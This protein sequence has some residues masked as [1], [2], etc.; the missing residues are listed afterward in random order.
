MISA[1]QRQ[2]FLNDVEELFVWY[3]EKA[4]E[5]TA[6]AFKESLKATIEILSARPFKGRP[7]PTR[8][9]RLRNLRLVQV[10]APFQ[11][12]LVFY[13]ASETELE[14]VR[15]IHGARDLPRRLR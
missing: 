10:E 5:A 7:Y 12:I 15:L 2:R 11:K 9:P 6:L 4:D 8:D 14:L 13:S 1:S 3:L